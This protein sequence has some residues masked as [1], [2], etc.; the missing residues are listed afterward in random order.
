MLQPRPIVYFPLPFPGEPLPPA[1]RLPI[2]HGE[3]MPSVRTATIFKTACIVTLV[4]VTGCGTLLSRRRPK[5]T[6]PVEVNLRRKLTA[7][8][9]RIPHRNSDVRD[10]NDRHTDA[11]DERN[12]DQ[13]R[14]DR[15]SESNSGPLTRDAE[16]NKLIDREFPEV[17]QAER[18]KLLESVEL[19]SVAKAKYMLKFAGQE[20]RKVKAH[21]DGQAFARHDSDDRTTGSRERPDPR[22]RDSRSARHAGYSRTANDGSN[23]RDPHPDAQYDQE[24]DRRPGRSQTNRNTR[25][26]DSSDYRFGSRDKE[27]ENGIRPGDAPDN[28]RPGITDRF[29]QPFGLSGRNGNRNAGNPAESRNRARLAAAS[30]EP[31]NDLLQKLIISSEAKVSKNPADGTGPLTPKAQLQHIRDHVHLRL[32][33]LI[34]GQR[35]LAIETIPGLEPNEQAFWRNTLWSLAHYFD[36]TKYSDRSQRASLV[37]NYMRSAIDRLSDIAD[38]EIPMLV[39]CTKI[40]NFGVY[41]AVK[42]PVFRAGE[43]ALIYAEIENFSSKLNRTDG[44]Y[45]TLLKSTISIYKEKGGKATEDIEFKAT[46]DLCLRRRRD[47]FHSYVI[48]L[49]RKLAPGEYQLKLMVTDMVGEKIAVE[50]M[51]FTID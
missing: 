17:S 30:D 31:W 5:R 47:Y 25:R 28:R 43:R 51:K 32:M 18:R 46:K 13:D 3:F 16:L 39:F 45:L 40:T 2:D 12:F 44:R 11:R 29:L 48:D 27:Q 34:S 38:L 20:Y 1:R 8:E 10:S 36:T 7:D 50:T 21:R 35:Q 23:E 37:V 41:D 6:E 19:V 22:F 14:D 15:P 49:P 42:K 26:R 9:D 33:Y 24:W 4:T